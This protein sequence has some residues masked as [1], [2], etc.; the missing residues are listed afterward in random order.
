MNNQ[1]NVGKYLVLAQQGD[2]LAQKQLGLLLS[3]NDAT[4]YDGIVWLKKA[5][6]TDAEA[7][8]LLGKIY[9][10][11]LENPEKAFFWYEQA[12]Q[13]EHVDSMNDVAAL[14][15][16]GCGVERSVDRA[17]DWYQKATRYNSP[18]AYHNLG[19][20]CFQ[21]EELHST[22]IDYFKKACKLGYADSAYLLGVMFI[23]G[24]GTEK[25]PKAALDYFTLAYELGKHFTCRPL[26]DL[27]V[28]GAFD[29]GQQNFEKAIAWYLRGAEKQVLSCV[30]A[31]GFCYY[32]GFG[33]NVDPGLAFDFYK[34][35]AE[36]GSADGA[37]T[38]GR[39]YATGE[40]VKTNY[41]EALK[42]MLVAQN[43]N[44][45]QA[46]KYVEVLTG[47]VNRNGP[48]AVTPTNGGSIGIQLRSSYSAD[49]EAIEV[50]ERARKEEK[51]KRSASIYAAAGAMSGR[52]SHTDYE[53]GSVI[54]PNG[55]VS[56]VDTDL[57]IIL[58]ADGS[59]SSH[60]SNTGFT[61]NYSTG[62]AMAYDETFNATY[63]FKSGNVSYNFDGFTI[64]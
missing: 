51:R 62:S 4:L 52:G 61:Y 53:M 41:R 9:L 12:A 37:F 40:F 16:F 3:K 13:N 15:L 55:E 25:D 27:Y 22:A 5:A 60:D 14:Y 28:Q 54:G 11:K 30:E 20:L 19:F 64:K 39:M 24:Y 59:V 45:P 6:E 8:Y 29:E 38:I 1:N 35:A 48:A 32:N 26:G 31:L 63:D 33:V 47:I 57:G 34:R 2:V 58:G 44:H 21:K 23:Y 43:K 10:K 50:E 49:L 36:M 7:M 17:V 42:W 18:M 46:T 56:Y